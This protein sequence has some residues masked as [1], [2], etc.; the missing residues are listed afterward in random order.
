MCR[1]DELCINCFVYNRTQKC[2]LQSVCG[3]CVSL[4]FFKQCMGMMHLRS[5]VVCNLAAK[6][7][8]KWGFGFESLERRTY[9]GAA[10]I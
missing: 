4:L 8:L 7:K 10:A 9:V 3:R 6:N 5:A 2:E 1:L